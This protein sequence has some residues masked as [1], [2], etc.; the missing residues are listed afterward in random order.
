MLIFFVPVA[1]A[2]LKSPILGRPQGDVVADGAETKEEV[3]IPRF[4]PLQAL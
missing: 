1:E 2:L 3:S 4:L